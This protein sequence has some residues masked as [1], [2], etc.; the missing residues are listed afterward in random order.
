MEHLEVLNKVGG[1]L[2]LPSLEMATTQQVADFY[3]TDSMVIK[4]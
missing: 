4:T 3:G 2:T 1:L